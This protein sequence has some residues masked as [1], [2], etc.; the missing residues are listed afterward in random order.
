MKKP[1]YWLLLVV[2]SLFMA[3]SGKD[4]KVLEVTGTLKNLDNITGSFN[5]VVNNGKVKL[6]LYEIQFGGEAAPVLLDTISIPVDQQTFHL[7]GAALNEGGLYNLSIGEGPVIPI[8]NDSKAISLDIDFANKARFYEVKGSTAST[9][10]KDFIFTYS[11]QRGVVEK[12]VQALDSLKQFQAGDSA[13]LAATSKKNQALNELNAYLKNFLSNAN[14]STVASFALGRAA[15]TMPITE[16]EASLNQATQKFPQDSNLLDL[17]KKYESFKAQ[18]EERSASGSWVGKKAPELVL[19]DAKGKDVAL[20]SFKG[21]YVLVDFWASWCGPCRAENPNVVFA[22]QQFKDKNFTI[23][24][25]SLDQDRGRWLDAVR[26]DQLAWTQVS[27]L[28]YW[29]SKAVST[30]GFN[31]IPFNVLIDPEGTVIAQGLR[32]EALEEK[33][34]EVLK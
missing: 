28:A 27:D 32:G 13:I 4:K 5:N 26:K 2:P 23:L 29:S 20:S 24:G 18:Q 9:Q 1:F 8:I 17:K 6:A 16:F 12:Q 10:L 34:R 25:V 11:D 14:Q 30:F 22:Y 15:A 31:G 7:K 21:K 33:L 3:C 19:P